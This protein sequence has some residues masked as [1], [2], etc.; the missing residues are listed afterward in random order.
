M[1]PLK[2]LLISTNNC[3]TP[4]AVFPLGVS[5]VASALI[6]AGYDL[7]IIDCAINNFSLENIIKEFSPN[8]I[9]ISLR[10]IDDIRISDTRFF[11]DDIVE[12]CEKIKKTTTVPIIIGGSGYALFPEKLLIK[13]GADYGILGEAEET[14]PNLLKCI[15][16]KTFFYNIPGLVFRSN[17]NIIVNAPKSCET[18]KILPPFFQK[19]IVDFYVKKSSMLNIQTQRG[20]AYKCCYCTYPIIEGKNVRFKSAYQLGEELEQI[21][22][23]SAKYF[24]IVDSVFNTSNDHV[25]NFCEE[26]VKRKINLSWGC[27][28]RPKGLSQE[29]MNLMKRAGLSHIEFGS[30]SFCDKVLEEYEK[31]FS[32]DDIFNSSEYARKSNIHYAHF[33]IIGGPGESE[34]TIKES[35]NNSKRLKKTV[36]FP[37]VGMRVYPDT[38]LYYRALKEKVIT[39]DTNLLPPYFY[40]SPN[41]KKEKIFDLLNIFANESKNWIIG[42]LSKDNSDV[43]ERLRSIGVVGPLWEFLVK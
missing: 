26:I 28:L 43:A 30:D 31:D 11:V 10:N 19:D 36:V 39:K 18:N 3:I 22:K 21:K 4:Y 15:Q 35:Y 42:E 29:L 13:T 34:E 12:L 32:F 33:L 24:F 37:F 41:L 8:F 25:V 20:C 23:T 5:H 14:L 6:N 27:F 1:M 2:V 9:G 40:V 38:S 16:K 7:K 17:G